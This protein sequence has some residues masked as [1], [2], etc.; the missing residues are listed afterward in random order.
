[1]KQATII[2]CIIM[3]C[4]GTFQA[5]AN[6]Y[7]NATITLIFAIFLHQQLIFTKGKDNE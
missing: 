7:H 2:L 1:M 3:I 5:L 4:W 6:N